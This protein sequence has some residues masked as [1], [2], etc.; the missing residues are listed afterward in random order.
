MCEGHLWATTYPYGFF[1]WLFDNIVNWS[2][3]AAS[4]HKKIQNDCLWFLMRNSLWH[5]IIRTSHD[6][7][8]MT[9][10]W[11]YGMEAWTHFEYQ[12]NSAVRQCSCWFAQLQTC[13]EATYFKN[14]VYPS[15]KRYD[16]KVVCLSNKLPSCI[17]LSPWIDAWS[18][19]YHVVDNDW[20]ATYNFGNLCV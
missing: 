13:W 18:E 1:L 16:D 3:T 9:S 6:F 12:A 8:T 14:S 10:L 17:H 15:C 11:R 2:L 5:K 19:H 4:F 20:Y 7:H